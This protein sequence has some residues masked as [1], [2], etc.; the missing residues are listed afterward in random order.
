MDEAEALSDVQRKTEL[1]NILYSGYKKYGYVYRSGK[2]SK[3]QIVPERFEVFSPKVFVTY[4]G[5]EEILSDRS[6]NIVMI[7]TGNKD[8]ADR[9]I[10]ETDLIWS[11]LRN[12]LYIFA[13]KNWKKIREIYRTF[14][15]ITEIHS[16]DLELWKPILV[17][18]KFFGDNIF[19][20]IK[21]LAITKI[22]EKEMREET[23]T[24][25]ILLLST[26][27][28]MVKEDGL[29]ANVDI[30]DKVKELYGEEFTTDWI[31]KTLTQEFGFHEMTRLS[32]KGRPTARRLTVS[33]ITELAKRYNAIKPSPKNNPIEAVQ[34]VQ[35]VQNTTMP[36]MR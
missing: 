23:E 31:G 32:R 3:E 20:D 1:K 4:E 35:D 17:L 22:K 10:D 24:R 26:L 6:I 18:A 36:P 8:I 19:E 7:R 28:E 13:L 2:T 14:E 11:D 9:E 25:E 34:D 16:R 30:R 5:L 27:T 33:K 29:Y 15:P 12:K 21:N